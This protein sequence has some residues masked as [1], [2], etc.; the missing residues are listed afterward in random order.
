MICCRKTRFTPSYGPDLTTP[1]L[2][3]AV[4]GRSARS[5]ALNKALRQ[6]SVA[7][8]HRVPL[9]DSNSEVYLRGATFNLFA[10]KSVFSRGKSWYITKGRHNFRQK[11]AFPA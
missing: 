11:T 9:A 5:P 2:F 4:A 6:F 1:P 3:S 10:A 8:V 7:D